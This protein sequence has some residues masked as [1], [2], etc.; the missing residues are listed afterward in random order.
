[1]NLGLWRIW[2][3]MRDRV[4]LIAQVHDA[5]YFEF[6]EHLDEKEIVTEALALIDIRLRHGNRELIVPGEAKSGWNWGNY[7][8]ESNPNGLKK[9]GREPDAR[10]R[11]GE[12][13][14]VL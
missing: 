5:V 7:D 4:Q 1:M 14:R 9:L 2:K 8:P 12:L 10:K 11:L 13:E 6:P 3:N